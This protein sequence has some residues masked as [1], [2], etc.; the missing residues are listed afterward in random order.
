MQRDIDCVQPSAGSPIEVSMRQAGENP[1][2]WVYLEQQ[3]CR[4]TSVAGVTVCAAAWK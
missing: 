2:S 3:I 4:D 1:P